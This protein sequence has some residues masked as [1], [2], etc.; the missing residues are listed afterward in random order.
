MEHK[1]NLIAQ[2]I[3]KYGPNNLENSLLYGNTG[4][5]IYLYHLAKAVSNS[6]YERA[7]DNLLDK[8]FASLNTSTSPDFESGLAGI[9]CGIEHLVLNGFAEG[10]TDE[11]LEDV[12]N[13]IFKILNEGT[14]VSFELING[15]TGYLFYLIGRLKKHSIPLSMVQLINRELLILTVNKLDEIVTTQFPSM[16][17]E[18]CFDLFWRFPVMFYGLFETYK[19]NIYNEKIKCMVK[20]WLPNLEAYIPSMHIN[21]LYMATILTQINELIPHKRLEKQIQV[22]LFA[23]DFEELKSEVDPHAL[24]I[25]FGWTGFVWVLQQASKI[26]PKTYPNYELIAAT[27]NEI[28]LKYMDHLENM[29]ERSLKD[30]PG[31]LGLANGIAGIGLMEL[32]WPEVFELPQPI[33]AKQYEEVSRSF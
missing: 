8:V 12:D 6:E 25:R 4:T 32:L 19:L 10:N 30:N 1:P 11:I 31:Q 14:I 16:V 7:A 13:K 22:L 15:L 3:H 2:Y 33:N 21:R 17:K 18:I 5:C 9:G 24:N 23:T 26:I 29:I 20:Q 27:A 28:K